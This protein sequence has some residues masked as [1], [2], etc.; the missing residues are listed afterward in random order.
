MLVSL[1]LRLESHGV[2]I[3]NALLDLD[4]FI[5]VVRIIAAVD[6]AAIGIAETT[7]GEALAVHLKAARLTAFASEVLNCACLLPYQGESYV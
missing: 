2:P 5:F 3:S 1:H 6:A 7:V 4:N